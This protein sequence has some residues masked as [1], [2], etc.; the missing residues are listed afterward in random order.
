MNTSN[1]GLPEPVI[2]VFF[3]TVVDEATVEDTTVDVVDESVET[4]TV[5]VVVE[6]GRTV[7]VAAP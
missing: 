2:G 7:V 1:L 5:V 6:V 4:P 3:T